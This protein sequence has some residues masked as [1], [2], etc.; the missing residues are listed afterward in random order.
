MTNEKSANNIWS[1]A[2]LLAFVPAIGY[3]LKVLHEVGY[4]NYF[5]I[6]SWLIRVDPATAFITSTYVL[7]FFFLALSLFYFVTPCLIEKFKKTP[8]YLIG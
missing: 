8:G 5:N 2:I 4:M 7:L 6:P 1:E 3:A